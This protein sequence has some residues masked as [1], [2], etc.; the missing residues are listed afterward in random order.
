ME[1]ILASNSKR[2][3]ELLKKINLKFKV[4]VSNFNEDS[5]LEN[6]RN[7][8]KYCLEL[9]FKKAGTVSKQLKN[10]LI[11][12]ADTIVYHKNKI[13]GKPKSRIDAF[14]YLSTLSN[15]THSVYT[16][17]SILNTKLNLKK[18]L[19]DETKVTFNKLNN[20]E[21]NYYIDNHDPYDKAGAY[22]I[23]G[24]SSVFVK[25]IDGCFYNVVGLPLP[26]FY[27]LFN[28]LNLKND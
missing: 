28:T 7:P 26:K 24:W 23:Q 6:H 4:V 5:I 19:I 1:I 13:I 18:S 8:E 10:D 21:I 17:V 12:G 11:I 25:K 14:N 3:K 16:G 22:G 20:S 9:A 15:S 2:R 27:K